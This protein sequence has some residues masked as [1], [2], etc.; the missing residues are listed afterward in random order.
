MHLLGSDKGPL[1]RLGRG[2]TAGG[3]RAH[4]GSYPK[5][6]THRILSRDSLAFG[7][8]VMQEKFPFP[9]PH[10]LPQSHSF[11]FSVGRSRSSNQVPSASVSRFYARLLCC[12]STNW[13]PFTARA[14]AP[15]Q[16]VTGC[17]VMLPQKETNNK[18]FTTFPVFLRYD[19]DESLNQR[20]T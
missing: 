11:L 15:S 5:E 17:H 8:R 16:R 3:S 14:Q 10:S 12:F 4:L 2:E 9:F 13:G 6:I 20:R 19:E 18:F 7:E 1:W